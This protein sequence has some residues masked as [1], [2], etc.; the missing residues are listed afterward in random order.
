MT[1]FTLHYFN[2]MGRAELLRYIFAAVDVKYEDHRIEQ[3]DWAAEK[4]KFRFGA[5][6]VLE[7]D[8]GVQLNQSIAIAHYLARE[9]KLAGKTTLEDAQCLALAEQVKDLLDACV[10]FAFHEKD[11]ARKAEKKKAFE[12][13]MLK[14]TMTAF[15]SYFKEHISASGYIIGN[16]LTWADLALFS[17]FEGLSSYL[18]H[19][20]LLDAYPTLKAHSQK[21]AGLPR[22]KHYREARPKTA[23]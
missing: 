7:I 20:N 21:I 11:E 1:K 10:D 18:G 23:F 8:D 9:F 6:P 17:G 19:P 14:N 12:E 15:E 16:E 3:Q 13:G 2:G 4:P 22:M 5:V